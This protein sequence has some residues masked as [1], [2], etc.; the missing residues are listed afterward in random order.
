V[1]EVR[2]GTDANTITQNRRLRAPFQLGLRCFM[3]PKC[4]VY[5]QTGNMG[6][7]RHFF[8]ISRQIRSKPATTR[9]WFRKDFS[10]AMIAACRRRLL[11]KR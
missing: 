7:S 2:R 10:E 11:Q 9:S 8:P 5:A 4:L 1:A 3:D 6:T